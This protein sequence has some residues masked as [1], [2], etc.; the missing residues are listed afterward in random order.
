MLRYGRSPS[1]EFDTYLTDDGDAVDRVEALAELASR[2]RCLATVQVKGKL[3]RAR[4]GS[5]V[6]LTRMRGVDV[7][8][9]LDAALF[10]IIAIEKAHLGAV[11]N[12]T[13]VE[14]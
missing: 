5:K 10:R 11:A 4:I 1:R 6:R 3:T 2:A 12:A 14:V 13:M 8:G 9:S 7:S